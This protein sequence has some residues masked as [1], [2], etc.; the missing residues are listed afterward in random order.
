MLDGR[1]YNRP[2]ERVPIYRISAYPDIKIKKSDKLVLAFSYRQER[3][4]LTAPFVAPVLQS[5]INALLATNYAS[6][7]SF[8]VTELTDAE[9]FSDELTLE[10]DNHLFDIGQQETVSQLRYVQADKT[11]YLQPDNVMPLL[12][13]G[14]SAFV[15]LKVTGQVNS[16]TINNDRLHA[17]GPWSNLQSQGI[18]TP[19]KIRDVPLAHVTVLS[20]GK[21]EQNLILYAVEGMP[22]L[23]A[24]DG[25]FG[26]QFNPEQ[27][28]V[29]GL[30]EYL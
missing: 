2:H 3:W 30:E 24:G 11:V 1:V 19:D 10:I 20:E 13:I 9:L 14:Q 7:R 28:K 12:E 29:L 16:V 21:R 6:D 18:I 25:S 5:R 27:A 26:Y 15:D 4:Y 17:T 22:V 8:T 23:M